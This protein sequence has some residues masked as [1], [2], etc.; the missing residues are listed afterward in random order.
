M[1][2]TLQTSLLSKSLNGIGPIDPHLR[3]KIKK[4]NDDPDPFKYK[5][6]EQILTMAPGVTL[7]ALS[8]IIS[9]Q[10]PVFRITT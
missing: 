7:S 6:S 9:W 3:P 10:R 2:E 4:D 5:K 8:F 1:D